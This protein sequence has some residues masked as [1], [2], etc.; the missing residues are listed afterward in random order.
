MKDRGSEGVGVVLEANE[1]A[2]VAGLPVIEGPEDRID[3][4]RENECANY[5][6]RRPNECRFRECPQQ[7]SKSRISTR[8]HLDRAVRPNRMIGYMALSRGHVSGSLPAEGRYGRLPDGARGGRRSDCRGAAPLAR[9]RIH[10]TS[11]D[12][13]PFNR[14]ESTHGTGLLDVSSF[15]FH[16][17]QADC[18]CDRR[19]SVDVLPVIHPGQSLSSRGAV[20][21]S[22]GATP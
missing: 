16:L 13:G 2:C 19:L 14:Y 8:D 18:S 11:G 4:R 7:L 5:D 20:A 9:E 21:P 15:G 10:H 6:K 3:S 12:L 17:L 22:G 1:R